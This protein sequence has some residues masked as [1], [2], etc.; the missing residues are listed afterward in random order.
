VW[1]H[2]A[3]GVSIVSPVPRRRPV[4]IPLGSG[5]RYEFTALAAIAARHPDEA[6]A[7]FGR[8]ARNGNGP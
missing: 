4:P 5:G 6:T 3:V 2:S 8:L 7:A 1:D